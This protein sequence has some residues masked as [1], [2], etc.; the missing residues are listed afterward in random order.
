[1]MIGWSRSPYRKSTIP[2]WPIRGNEMEPQLLPA[3]E[4]A[5]R[6]QQELFWSFLPRRSHQNCTFTS[7]CSLVKISSS[8]GPTTTAVCGPVL[9]GLGVLRCGRY[10]G[11][12]GG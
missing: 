4:L 2:S 8:G 7:P 12:G 5:T 1:M 10:G 9:R 11:G 3:H 6:I